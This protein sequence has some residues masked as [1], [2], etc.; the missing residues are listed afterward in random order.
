MKS[1]LSELL[2]IDHPII[3]AP[4]FLIS[5][6]KMVIEA[7]QNGITAAIP[8]LN[9][10]T[11]ADFR[12]AIEEIRRQTDKPFGVNLIV[13]KSNIKYKTQLETCIDTKVDFIITSLG[14]PREV[15]TKCKPLGIKVF[16]DVVDTVYAQKVVDL[17]ADALIAVTKEAG[18]HS[19]A[20]TA[21]R[22]IPALKKKFDIPVIGA[23]GVSRKEDLNKL[24]QLGAD[25]ISV[26]TVF[27]ASN[28]S[29]VSP[30]YKQAL[31]EY[32]AKDVVLSSNLSGSPLTV[33]NT[34]YVQKI[35]TEAGF[36]TKLM[37][38][39]KKLKKFIKMFIAVKGM[40]SIEKAAFKST[41]KTVWVA[42]P[43]IEHIHEIRPIK[44]IIKS[45]V[46]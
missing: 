45:L 25:G 30:E 38:K 5:N 12:K 35:G 39:N 40:K 22:L 4:M 33:I 32:G 34:P 18:G 2:N 24:L 28:E 19:G 16:C 1:K 21:A 10:R 20:Q 6:S 27:I 29:P 23:G 3:M 41:Y 31:V 13:N 8:A 9:Y 14:S 26:G 36:L 44:V 17:G 37:H 15:I 11:D 42:G 7:L 46:E 43:C